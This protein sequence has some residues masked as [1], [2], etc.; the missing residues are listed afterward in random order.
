[1]YF[2]P[3]TYFSDPFTEHF[4]TAIAVLA[5]TLWMELSENELTQSSDA[6]EMPRDFFMS[7]IVLSQIEFVCMGMTTNK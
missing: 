4:E 3:A 6:S 2:A 1:V 7:K 5:S